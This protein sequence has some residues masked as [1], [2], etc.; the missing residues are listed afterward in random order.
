MHLCLAFLI[1]TRD[2][3]MYHHL[4]RVQQI[5]CKSKTRLCFHF[6]NKQCWTTKLSKKI[7]SFPRDK[8][9]GFSEEAEP[10]LS[11][12]LLP[13]KFPTSSS[14][15]FHLCTGFQNLIS[16]RWEIEIKWVSLRDEE[17]CHFRQFCHFWAWG[18]EIYSKNLLSVR[19]CI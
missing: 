19:R 5:T 2:V 6:L 15:C 13:S 17:F 8:I 14:G 18:V 1:L 7:M 9:L 10:N 4:T 12:V 3:L 11:M 16:E